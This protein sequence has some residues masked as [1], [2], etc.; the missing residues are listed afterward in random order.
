MTNLQKKLTYLVL[1]LLIILLSYWMFI[2]WITGFSWLV[3]VCASIV[4][5]LF[6]LLYRV[7]RSI[8]D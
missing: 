5:I 2:Y 3:L 6:Y 1:L 4:V 7:A 8:D